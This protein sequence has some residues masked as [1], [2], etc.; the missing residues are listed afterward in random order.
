MTNRNPVT[1]LLLSLFTG[2]IYAIFWFIWTKD[3]MNRLGADIPTGWLMIIPFANYYFYWKWCVGV[4]RA[5]KA[6]MSAPLAFLL[7]F[8][9]GGLGGAFIQDK[10]NN[11][12]QET[13]RAE[14]V[15]E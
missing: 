4:E 3:E 15:V 10:F 12:G 11:V 2:G 9:L 1:V 13:V 5:T 6:E 8:V 14:A 7:I